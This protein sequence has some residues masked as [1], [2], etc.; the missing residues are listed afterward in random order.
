MMQYKH[1]MYRACVDGQHYHLC[2]YKSISIT[3]IQC[4]PKNC[5]V[6][7]MHRIF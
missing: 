1:A 3:L 7:Y 4:V 6:S 5:P 2:L